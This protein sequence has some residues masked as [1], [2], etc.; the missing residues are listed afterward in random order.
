M[1]NR[2]TGCLSAGAWPELAS[3]AELVSAESALPSPRRE[4]VLKRPAHL[5]RKPRKE[6]PEGGRGLMADGPYLVCGSA[7]AAS[8]AGDAVVGIPSSDLSACGGS[9]GGERRSPCH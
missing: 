7:R 8:D 4:P 3:G 1:P 6:V 2:K 9:E 5:W